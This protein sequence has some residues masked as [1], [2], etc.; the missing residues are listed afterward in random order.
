M[1]LHRAGAF[2]SLVLAAGLL[3]CDA[4][5]ADPDP[6]S[7][8]A[9]DAE[10]LAEKLL[11]AVGG[12][13]AWASLRGTVND[14]QQNQVDAPTVV[15]AVIAMDFRT[16]RFRI[17]SS[18]PGLEVTRV[19]DGPRDW[20]KNREGEILSFEAA[21]RADDLRWYQGHVYRTL[22]RIAAHDAGITLGIAQDG[23]LEVFDQGKRIAWYRLDARGEPYAFGAHDDEQG[24]LSGPWD[25]VVGDIRHPVWVSNR[26]GTWRARLL[27]LTLN[28]PLPDSLFARPATQPSGTD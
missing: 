23:R 11:S 15:R 7:H 9:A 24:S 1:I 19:M 8:P 26:E 17:D 20:R 6:A 5:A 18:A 10:A 2:V 16:P 4:M 28:P 22:H 27:E 13:T 25:H 14:S 12:R 3:L 21:L